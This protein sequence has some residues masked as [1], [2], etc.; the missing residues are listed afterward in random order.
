MIDGDLEDHG[1]ITPEDVLYARTIRTMHAVASHQLSLNVVPHLMELQFYNG[2]PISL[3]HV[4]RGALGDGGAPDWLEAAGKV[5]LQQSRERAANPMM[6][7]LFPSGIPF[8]MMGDGSSDASLREQ[9]AHALRFMGADG[10][11]YN[12]FYDLAELD[13]TQSFDGHSPDAQCITAC[14]LTSLS[15][16]DNIKNFLF[17]QNSKKALVQGSFD[18][19]TVMLG[20][21][22]GVA[23]RIKRVAPQAIFTHAAAHVTQVPV[24]TLEKSLEK[25]LATP[26]P[27]PPSPP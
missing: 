5:W 19:A 6:L 1:A 15:Q 24:P 9:E 23:A 11:P 14:Y 12:Q 4:G 27:Q 21:Q 10:R 13:L 22:N 26:K 17:K 25:M 20:K 3:M 8:G 2:L 7:T 16:M 18:G